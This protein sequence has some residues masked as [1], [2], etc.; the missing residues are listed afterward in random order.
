MKSRAVVTGYRIFISLFLVSNIVQVPARAHYAV[1][2]VVELAKRQVNGKP[3]AL[4]E[5]ADDQNI[6][7]PFLVQILQQLRTAGIV[8][9]SRGSSG[10]YF[11]SKSANQIS[12]L[13]IIEAV[14]PSLLGTELNVPQ[15]HHDGHVVAEMWKQLAVHQRDLLQ[16]IM[17]P[18]LLE[19]MKSTSV[20]MFYI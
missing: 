8:S 2:A 3:V 13:E 19:R 18:D 20:E 10:G 5:I 9:S 11:L 1:L 4:R 16:Q 7:M 6:P 15:S 12:M 17:L 14:C